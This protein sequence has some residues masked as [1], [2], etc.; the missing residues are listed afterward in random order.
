MYN[1]KI[2]E[3]FS[4]ENLYYDE[5]SGIVLNVNTGHIYEKLNPNYYPQIGFRH[6]GLIY[7][8]P[9]HRVAWFLHY[10]KW[11]TKCIDHINGDRH[12]NRINNLRDVGHI[13]NCRNLEAHRNGKT[14]FVRDM[15]KSVYEV[16]VPKNYEYYGSSPRQFIYYCKFQAKIASLMIENK[17]FKTNIHNNRVVNHFNSHGVLLLKDLCF[18]KKYKRYVVVISRDPRLSK[19]FD[20]YDD[21]LSFYKNKYPKRFI[22]KI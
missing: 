21:A 9:A 11:P 17:E 20:K 16:C 8:T 15:G 19:T 4:L 1:L 2:I 13:D 10:G 18:T 22:P 6:N 14:I 3:K 12:D 7:H 5:V